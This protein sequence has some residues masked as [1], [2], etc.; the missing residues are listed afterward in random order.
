MKTHRQAAKKNPLSGWD[1]GSACRFAFVKRY[2]QLL[3]GSNTSSRSRNGKP[4]V[5]RTPANPFVFV[6]SIVADHVVCI[7]VCQLPDNRQS[8]SNQNQP[9]YFKLIIDIYNKL[10][11]INIIS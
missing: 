10:L 11:N 8:I 9:E 1:A 2:P 5:A 7:S 4:A 6:H 3:P